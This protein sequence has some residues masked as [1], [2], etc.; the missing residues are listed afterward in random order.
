MPYSL[1]WASVI[2]AYFEWSKGEEKIPPEKQK[3]E[4][5]RY[6]SDGIAEATGKRWKI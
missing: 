1:N 6:A 4:C 2:F 3:N 5:G